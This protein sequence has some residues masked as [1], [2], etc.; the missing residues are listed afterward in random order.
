MKDMSV[1][2][3][4]D[5]SREYIETYGHHKG[6]LYRFA[7]CDEGNP[8]AC[9]MGAM[10]QVRARWHKEASCASEFH[11]TSRVHRKAQDRMDLYAI[12]QGYDGSA[13]NMLCPI[14]Q[15]NDSEA[16]STEDVLLG[17]KRSAETE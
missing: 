16:T 9:A 17:F 1:A 6:S 8:A 12:E 7:S 15:W 5:E 10:E 3:F 14:A 2:R 4:L 11:G 13:P